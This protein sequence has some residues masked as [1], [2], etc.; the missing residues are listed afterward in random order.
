LQNTE[1]APRLGSAGFTLVEV[2]AAMV[3]LAVGLLGLQGL[4]V[5]ASRVNTLSEKQSQYALT[6]SS[7]MEAARRRARDGMTASRD[8][9]YNFALSGRDTAVVRERITLLPNKPNRA[10]IIINVAPKN[11]GAS[12]VRPDTLTLRSYVWTPA[13]PTT[14]P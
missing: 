6:G 2:L 10:E 8:V 11:P 7:I 13:L 14:A 1:T 4:A 9:Q 5:G 3:I 12:R